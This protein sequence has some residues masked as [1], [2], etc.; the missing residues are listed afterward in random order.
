VNLY[1]LI[2]GVV[3]PYLLLVQSL[4][5]YN[6]SSPEKVIDIEL[7]LNYKGTCALRN[8]DSGAWHNSMSRCAS[9]TV[10]FFADNDG[11]YFL[12]LLGETSR[13]WSTENLIVYRHQS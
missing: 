4:I 3:S 12:S 6:L 8:Q 10:T 5:Q 11:T 2:E 13:M 9:Q 1:P 7:W